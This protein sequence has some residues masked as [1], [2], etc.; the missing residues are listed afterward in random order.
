[1]DAFTIREVPYSMLS[2][3]FP[4]LSLILMAGI[5]YQETSSMYASLRKEAKLGGDAGVADLTKYFARSSGG[6]FVLS[7]A[8]IILGKL[9]CISLV[10]LLT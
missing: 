3:I 8:F 9:A 4:I 2:T 6:L 7:V 5:G 1:M 10:L